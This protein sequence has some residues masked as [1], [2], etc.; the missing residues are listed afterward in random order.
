MTKVHLCLFL[1]SISILLNHTVQAQHPVDQKVRT[2]SKKIES[3]EIFGES[4][5]GFALYDPQQKEF[6][7]QYNANKF[8]TPASNT[9]IFTLHTALQILGDSLPAIH[10]LQHGDS[11]I[12]WGTGYPGFLNPYLPQDSTL[13]KF[14]ANPKNQLFY[15]DHTFR[16]SHFGPGWAWD[17]YNA[18][19]QAEKTA[20]P[21]YGNIA[22]FHWHQKQLQATPPYFEKKLKANAHSPGNSLIKRE[23][24][25]NLFWYKPW[26]FD[27][28]DSIREI[29]FISSPELVAQLLEDTL[30]KKVQFL[31]YSSLPIGVRETLHIKSRDTLYQL[32][33]HQSDNFIAEQLLLMCSDKLFGIQNTD[34]LIEY[35]EEALFGFAPDTLA[36]RDGSGLSRY[37][38]FTPRTIV[39]V[40]DRLYEEIPQERLFKLFP[41]GGMSGTIEDWYGSELPFLFA[42]TGSLSNKHCLSGYVKPQS[43][44]ILIFSFMHNNF[45]NGSDSLKVKMENVLQWIKNEF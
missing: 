33:M 1:F 35:A 26:I 28:K 7:L 44:R 36:W 24:D 12:F 18:Y 23:D 6:L 45:I 9:K 43:G 34:R 19:Y 4:F 16:D 10:Y 20:F 5:T 13:N 21:I 31:P 2:L 3:S 15:A 14:L 42:K 27:Q 8:F 30:K 41:A 40:L 17:D 32:L 29:P 39:A 22:T 37:N 38:L 25:E 11:L